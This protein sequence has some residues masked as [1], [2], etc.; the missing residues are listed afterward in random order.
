MH[1]LREFALSPLRL[2]PPNSAWPILTGPLCGKKWIIDS[3]RRAYWVG[4]YERHFQR[5]LCQ[6][7]K[8]SSVFYDIG[9]NVGFYSLL[10]SGLVKPGTVFSFEPVP[11]NVA[12]LRRHV[13]LNRLSNVQVMEV[14]IADCDGETTF[15]ESID[16]ASGYIGG[17]NLRVSV[18]SVDCLLQ[19]KQI[20][21]PDCM[22]IDVEG[23]EAKVLL[24]ARD[25]LMRYKP[26]IF[27]ATHGTEVHEECRRLLETWG[28]SFEPLSL[29]DEGRADVV[30]RPVSLIRDAS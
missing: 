2:L 17:G 15:V 12:Y 10:A 27:L 26:T 14:A 21:P 30:V 19:R 18:T 25:C 5:I 3:G 23:A 13:A 1:T 9:A 24:G 16:N 28:F 4:H 6:E 20:A 8:P 11:R 7:L 22:K 29:M